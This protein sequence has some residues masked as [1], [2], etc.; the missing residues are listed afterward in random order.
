MLLVVGEGDRASALAGALSAVCEVAVADSVA[1]AAEILGADA[2]LAVIAVD[3]SLPDGQADELLARSRVTHR[4]ARRLLI[5]TA[6]DPAAI[7]AAVNAAGADQVFQAPAEPGQIADAVRT[8]IASGAVRAET[9][10]DVARIPSYHERFT[11]VLSLLEN[12][13]SLSCLF[14]DMSC[15]RR[16]EI[17]HGTA[18]HAEVVA[19]IGAVLSGT[20]GEHL[21]RDDLLCRTDDG[22]GYVCFLTPSR[23][24]DI[25]PPVDLESVS[26]R[27]EAVLENQVSRELYEL[28]RDRLR[29]AVGYARVLNNPMIRSE[30]LVSRLI[31]DAHQSAALQQK[32]SAQRDKALLQEIILHSE[33]YPVY[34]PIVHLDSADIF[35]YESLIR[36]PRGTT[37]EAPTALFSVAD[38]VDLTFELDRACFHSCL[39]S[40][41]Q[42]EPVH[43]LFVNLLPMSFYDTTFIQSE[44]RRLIES[45]SITPANVVFEITEKLAIENFRSFKNA[46]GTLTSAGFGVAIDD[47]GTRH[48]NLEAVMALRPH[49]IKISDVLTRGVSRSTVKREMLR[50]LGRIAEAIDAV[51]VAEGLENPDDLAVVRDLGVH[52]GQGF[53]LARPA[54]PFASLKPEISRAVRALAGRQE[55]PI[56]AP[57]LDYDDSGDLAER[58]HET[59]KQAVIA[60]AH[61][62]GEMESEEANRVLGGANLRQGSD[63]ADEEPT[64]SRGGRVRKR[65]LTLT[66]L[67]LAHDNIAPEDDDSPDSHPWMPLSPAELGKAD[68]DSGDSSLMA[69]LRRGREAVDATEEPTGSGGAA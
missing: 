6:T 24:H 57:P 25:A 69:S 40:A 43:R 19:V 22:D 56:P 49:F 20:R 17:E 16:L 53:F 29:L 39:A 58:A 23:T 12:A 47:V 2:G 30:R 67:Y 14:V 44:L 9:G 46:L 1:D 18:K 36:G 35:G 10:A 33:L 34:Q 41:E 21:R 51:V 65:S 55:A 66:P 68:E 50:S 3:D 7:I 32:Q 31:S 42:L 15:L 48:S 59:I 4:H 60:R 62:S 26:A 11:T 64:N 8:L 38:E 13:G 28:S 5:T 52:Y 37:L 61:E 63:F 27:I 45:A 54:P